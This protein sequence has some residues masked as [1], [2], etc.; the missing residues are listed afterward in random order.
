M[1][2]QVL[3]CRS[4]VLNPLEQSCC[5]RIFVQTICHMDDKTENKN[6]VRRQTKSSAASGAVIDHSTTDLLRY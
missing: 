3:N 5:R 4:V 2:E 1:Y 6:K